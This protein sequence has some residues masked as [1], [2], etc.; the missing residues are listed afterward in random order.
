M[1][2]CKAQRRLKEICIVKQ[3]PQGSRI[4]TE[5]TWIEYSTKTSSEH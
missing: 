2:F 5:I 3:Q 4:A 1:F